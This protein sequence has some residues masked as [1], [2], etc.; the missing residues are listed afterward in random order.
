MSGQPRSRRRSIADEGVRGP[1]GKSGVEQVDAALTDGNGGEE[2][3][4]RRRELAGVDLRVAYQ[5]RPLCRGVDVDGL[6]DG[7]AELRRRLDEVERRRHGDAGQRVDDQPADRAVRRVRWNRSP[8]RY[9]RY[10]DLRD[11]GLN[12]FLEC[13]KPSSPP[14]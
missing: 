11:F 3:D 12:L 13:V 10:L 8:D 14:S 2:V 7:A 9:L 6:R 1:R 4:L 5:V